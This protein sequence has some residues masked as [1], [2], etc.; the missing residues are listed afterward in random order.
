MPK[1]ENLG[2]PHCS[3]KC[4]IESKLLNVNPNCWSLY[5]FS[6]EKLHHTLIP[7]SA[8]IHLL[9][10]VCHS[11][12]FFWATLYCWIFVNL[13]DFYHL[14]RAA[15]SLFLLALLITYPRRFVGLI[16]IWWPFVMNIMIT[17]CMFAEWSY[18]NIL[19]SFTTESYIK[20]DWEI[21]WSW[22]LNQGHSS[23]PGI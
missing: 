21:C 13:Y 23:S 3:T 18:N 17:F 7:I 4:A 20:S 15:Q 5:H 14:K 12:F 19:S 22:C 2:P 16:C 8:C 6:Q 11:V 1:M 9:W 10:E